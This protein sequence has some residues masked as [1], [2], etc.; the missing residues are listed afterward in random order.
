L[1]EYNYDNL[2]KKYGDLQVE[3]LDLTNKIY[4]LDGFK[5]TFKNYIDLI[6]SG[7]KYY[8]TVNNSIAQKLDNDKF[9]DFYSNLF[10]IKGFGNIFIGNK[11]SFTHMHA[12]IAASCAL[13]LNGIKKWY[14]VN[15]KYSLYLHTIPDKDKIYYIS[16]YSFVHDNYNNKN[17]DLIPHYEIYCN[18]GDF[19]YV[20]PWWWHEAINI[21]NES[22][23]YS[24]RP[25]L[26]ITPYKTNIEYTL[27]TPLKTLGFNQVM[28]PFLTELNIIDKNEDIVIKSIQEIKK[29][30]PNKFKIF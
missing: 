16:L 8:L 17:I 9:S 28:F 1:D 7:K 25:P 12:E 19:L 2:I 24:F 10:D 6:N 5:T 11:D 3:V 4:N 30:I 15:P 18:K 14:L 21:T 22:I 20:P 26:F 29:R 13:Q 23:M 27:S